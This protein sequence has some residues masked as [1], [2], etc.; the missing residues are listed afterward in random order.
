MRNINKP[1]SSISQEGETNSLVYEVQRISNCLGLENIP[2]VYEIE[3]QQRKNVSEYAR[4]IFEN[5][6]ENK[7]TTPYTEDWYSEVKKVFEEYEK[8]RTPGEYFNR[9]LLIINLVTNGVTNPLRTIQ[10]L[11]MD[12]L[13]ANLYKGRSLPDKEKD[14]ILR[15][16]I[17]REYKQISGKDKLNFLRTC[18]DFFTAQRRYEEL[19]GQIITTIYIRPENM[20][21]ALKLKRIN[22]VPEEEW[23]KFVMQMNRYP[24]LFEREDTKEKI[25]PLM[26]IAEKGGL[27]LT[28]EEIYAAEISKRICALA[29]VED[30]PEHEIIKKPSNIH[31]LSINI[32]RLTDELMVIEALRYETSR[33]LYDSSYTFKVL[34]QLHKDGHLQKLSTLLRSGKKLGDIIEIFDPR[35]RYPLQDQSQN[36]LQVAKLSIDTAYNLIPTIN[37]DDQPYLTLL[38]SILGERKREAWDFRDISKLHIT[39]HL[40]S[41]EMKITFFT[42]ADL[43]ISTTPPDQRKKVLSTILEP[44]MYRGLKVDNFEIKKLLESSNLTDLSEEDKTLWEFI[45][46]NKIYDEFNDTILTFFITHKKELHQLR[47]NQTSFDPE[48]FNKMVAYIQNLDSRYVKANDIRI[49]E[50]HINLARF[51]LQPEIC[52]EVW[53]EL[54]LFL[55]KDGHKEYIYCFTG[56]QDEWNLYFYNGKPQSI[57][58]ERLL[59]NREID[60]CKNLI[61]AQTIKNYEP[62]QK[63]FWEYWLTLPYN[64]QTLSAELFLD[65]GELSPDFIDRIKVLKQ[66]LER[67]TQSLPDELRIYEVQIIQKLFYAENPQEALDEFIKIFDNE[68][69]PYIGRVYLLFEIL[70]RY[71]D[72]YVN[73]YAAPTYKNYFQTKA[74]TKYNISPILKRSSERRRYDIIYRDLLRI[75]IDSNN[76]SLRRYLSQLQDGEKL[77]TLLDSSNHTALDNDQKTQLS[78]WLDKIESL[79]YTS[80]L[81]KRSGANFINV[82]NFKSRLEVLKTAL[83][84]RDGQSI[85]DRIVEMFARPLGYNNIG[86][87]LNRMDQAQIE[88]TN[89]NIDYYKEVNGTYQIKPGDLIKGIQPF[90]LYSYLSNGV[91]APEYIPGVNSDFTPFDTDFI[92]AYINVTGTELETFINNSKAINYTSPDEGILIVIRDRGQLKQHLPNDTIRKN[93]DSHELIHSKLVDANHF[94]IRTG[95]PSTEIDALIVL[96]GLAKKTEEIQRIGFFLTLSGKYIPII[97]SR[98]GNYLYDPNSHERN[99]LNFEA[100]KKVIATDNYTD[101]KL[102]QHLMSSEYMRILYEGP[103]NDPNEQTL[104][105]ETLKVMSQLNR[106]FI[107][108][109]GMLLDKNQFR[110][111]LSLHKIDKTIEQQSGPYYNH[112][113]GIIKVVPQILRKIGWNQRSI[114]LVDAIINQDHMGKYINGKVSLTDTEKNIRIMAQRLNVPPNKL[115]EVITVYYMASDSAFNED[116]DKLSPAEYSEKYIEK[117]DDLLTKLSEEP[118]QQ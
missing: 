37:D 113:E 36:I 65:A 86:D 23:R 100:I 49:Q 35:N 64:I 33:P 8:R 4:T 74:E 109:P 27:T 66:T 50:I 10:M 105:Q 92:R 68:N 2:T 63:N 38:T 108:K 15:L 13:K 41:Q 99:L 78:S 19:T 81:R 24:F 61:N 107:E 103:T 12:T 89:R 69:L 52:P 83:Q 118:N 53:K 82:D 40:L 29:G 45:K 85:N 21:L 110:V 97:D 94:G 9:F 16:K 28:Q 77:L 88:S 42:I 79:Y 80:G 48:L 111:L 44:I 114:E 102:I 96:P 72:R 54:G 6:L 106:Y 116:G 60:F 112:Q 87:V 5:S 32:E 70:H 51:V 73:R 84:V 76:P 59:Q 7:N 57:F 30:V 115:L 11:E 98:N 62:T 47:S 22:S 91:V 1:D 90:F 18:G 34:K 25:G 75:H 56:K 101:V 26:E 17:E 14:R 55:L 95:I 20:E 3:R 93:L 43:V 104:E 46:Q 67:L 71:V 58:F 39:E 31:D 117:Y